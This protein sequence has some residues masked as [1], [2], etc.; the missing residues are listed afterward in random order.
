MTAATLSKPAAVHV[1][2]LERFDRNGSF[3]IPPLFR[4]TL[5]EK[6]GDWHWR[7]LREPVGVQV[8]ANQDEWL[9]TEP[10]D[11]GELRRRLAA[12]L[13][14]RKPLPDDPGAKPE[15]LRR[16]RKKLIE[17]ARP[18]ATHLTL[19]ADGDF[20]GLAE[21]DR[22]ELAQ[23]SAATNVFRRPYLRRLT[24]S[25]RGQLGRGRLDLLD[26]GWRLTDEEISRRLAGLSPDEWTRTLAVFAGCLLFQ[27]RKRLRPEWDGNSPEYP[28][29]RSRP[30]PS[31]QAPW[32][33]YLV[34]LL[35]LVRNEYV[36]VL[37]P[38]LQRWR[39]ENKR[40][41]GELAKTRVLS[42]FDPDTGDGRSERGHDGDDSDDGLPLELASVEDLDARIDAM[43]PLLPGITP[44]VDR[45][46]WLIVR[47]NETREAASEMLGKSK[48]WGGVVLHR[49]RDSDNPRVAELKWRLIRDKAIGV[50]DPPGK[51]KTVSPRTHLGFCGIPPGSVAHTTRALR[52]KLLFPS[53]REPSREQPKRWRYW[54]YFCPA[55]GFVTGWFASTAEA[56]ESFQA[57][58]PCNESPPFRELVHVGEYEESYR[59]RWWQRPH[60]SLSVAE[61][62]ER[63]SIALVTKPM[64]RP[65]PDGHP[66]NV[67]F[68]IDFR[69]KLRL[70]AAE[71]ARVFSLPPSHP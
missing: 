25:H 24:D 29:R 11:R 34:R 69:R 49:L 38:G 14:Y 19:I 65:L 57:Q 58:H 23:R 53:L 15:S 52:G 55:C 12:T 47:G 43:R 20:F 32:D 27:H 37:A 48:S 6:C 5:C 28:P 26:K 40:S 42:E 51:G 17:D 13:R 50:I 61:T 70:G 30:V 10:E 45:L 7:A 39:S 33:L 44:E 66:S 63:T 54:C 2:K 21:S 4:F 41:G 71:S 31:N 60:L 62:L 36:D 18:L 3:E 16:I 9:A 46:L 8:T 1:D 68:V 56:L 59:R 67:A 64:G 22:F 35:S